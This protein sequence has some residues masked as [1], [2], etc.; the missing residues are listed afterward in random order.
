MMYTISFLS[1][2]VLLHELGIFHIGR[3][4]GLLIP[5]FLFQSIVLT[6]QPFIYNKLR[7]NQLNELTKQNTIIII[8]FAFMII[9]SGLM[10]QYIILAF[11][12]PEYL[13][14]LFL[15]RLFLFTFIFKVIYFLPM[16]YLFYQNKTVIT[17]KIEILSSCIFLIG[18]HILVPY[19][20][21]EGIAL[22]LGLQEVFRIIAFTYYSKMKLS[23]IIN[24]KQL[25]T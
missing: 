20:S 4:L 1:Q 8:L 25:L 16:I 10:M 14:A 6:Y 2:H 21:I 9:I 22:S 24:F 13:N 5:D 18:I 19:F 12:T 7:N 17:T 3:N 15:S 23:T 11:T